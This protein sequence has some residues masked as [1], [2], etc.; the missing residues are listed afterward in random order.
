MAA[1]S[2][3]GSSNEQ[4]GAPAL[5]RQQDSREHVQAQQGLVAQ[6]KEEIK[7]LVQEDNFAAAGAKMKA[8]EVAQ[9]VLGQ[10]GAC[11]AGGTCT[12]TDR[13]AENNAENKNREEL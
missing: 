7:Q 13:E 5:R 3:G 1:A 10:M 9:Q 8:L 4:A 2:G 6:L 12:A 11:S